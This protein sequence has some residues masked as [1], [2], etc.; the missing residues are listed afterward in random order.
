MTQNHRDGFLVRVSK[1]SRLRFVGC[2]TKLTGGCDGMGHAS[3]S[4]GLFYMK[5]SLIR[6]SQSGLKSGGCA[7][8][9]GARDTITEVMSDSS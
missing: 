8:T 3:R 1:S 6:V 7:M 9:G 4:S 2:A 5:A